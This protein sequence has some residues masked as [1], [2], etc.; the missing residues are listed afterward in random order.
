MVDHAQS[1]DDSTLATSS[2]LFAVQ[3][4]SSSNSASLA[5]YRRLSQISNPGETKIHEIDC[6]SLAAAVHAVV[7]IPADAKI[8]GAVKIAISVKEVDFP[9]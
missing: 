4:H 3:A 5:R 8:G 9:L 6:A 7:A 1:N 2:S